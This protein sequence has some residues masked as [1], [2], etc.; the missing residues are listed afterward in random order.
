MY[1]PK[2]ALLYV[3]NFNQLNLGNP[4]AYQFISK[5]SPDGEIIDLKWI[6]NLDNPLG[7]T[8]HNDRIY[9]A[10]RGG[11]AIIDPRKG[12]RVE[13]LM[14]EGSIFLNDIP[15]DKS[16]GIYISDTRRNS[17]LKS[18]DETFVPWLEGS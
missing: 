4:L 7:I 5:L 11:V 2:R 18:E 8:L 16:I 9:V 6:D 15:V 14:I 12:E 3:T 13:N 17:I 10:E 1:D